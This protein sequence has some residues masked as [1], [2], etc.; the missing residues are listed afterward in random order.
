MPCGSC[1]RTRWARTR[2][3]RSGQHTGAPFHCE[4]QRRLLAHPFDKPCQAGGPWVSAELQGV[5]SD[6]DR[7]TSRRSRMVTQHYHF[8]APVHNDRHQSITPGPERHDKAR[9]WSEGLLVGRSQSMLLV[10]SLARRILAAT[11]VPALSMGVF[12]N[13]LG[14]LAFGAFVPMIAS[15]LHTSVALIG[16]VPALMM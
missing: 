2:L 11:L 8:P 14:T 15:E 12:F 5:E 4:R 9:S 1:T 16:Q 7:P 3:P 10:N 13:F 6:C